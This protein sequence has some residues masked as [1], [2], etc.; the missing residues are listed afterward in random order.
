MNEQRE[1]AVSLDDVLDLLA[2]G[3]LTVR[4]LLPGSSNYTFLA[5][6]SNERTRDWPSTSRDRARRRCGT[7]LTAP[8]TG[9]S[10][11]RMWSAR[12]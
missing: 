6:V 4:G 12:R 7:F 8:C 10:W 5:D 3:E 2:H 9:A 11:P 1:P